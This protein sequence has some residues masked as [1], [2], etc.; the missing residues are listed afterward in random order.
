MRTM[1][2]IVCIGMCVAMLTGAAL[3]EGAVN[4]GM[5]PAAISQNQ[6]GQQPKITPQAAQQMLQ[7]IEAQEK[8]TQDKVKKEK[9][10]K[11]KSKQK[12]KNW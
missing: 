11:L 8:D 2:K 5:Q 1:K 10:A 6:Q 3:A 7:A 9:A 12:E 4:A